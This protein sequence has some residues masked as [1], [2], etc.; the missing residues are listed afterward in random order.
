MVVASNCLLIKSKFFDPVLRAL[1]TV[2]PSFLPGL[3]HCC[4]P[5]W[6]PRSSQMWLSPLCVS[7]S[8]IFL[9]IQNALSQLTPVHTQPHSSFTSQLRRYPPQ[10]PWACTAPKAEH[11]SVLT[12]QDEASVCTCLTHSSP[13]PVVTPDF[14]LWEFI[15]LPYQF[16]CPRN[17]YVAETLDKVTLI[18]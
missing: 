13:L 16:M 6:L 18:N 15:F 4:S 9:S 2:A 14:P 11:V 1:H 17:G 7:P 8:M 3:F 12:V 10:L 5:T